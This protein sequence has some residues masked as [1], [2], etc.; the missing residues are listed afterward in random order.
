[1]NRPFLHAETPGGARTH[2]RRVERTGSVFR[3]QG[4]GRTN[5]P[6]GAHTRM[7]QVCAGLAR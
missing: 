7:R 5:E 2:A 6:C 3:Q 1:M 4:R